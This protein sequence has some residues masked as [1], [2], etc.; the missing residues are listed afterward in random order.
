MRILFLAAAVASVAAGCGTDCDLS[1][2]PGVVVRVVNSATGAPICDATV[3]VTDGDWH[4]SVPPTV[5]NFV[6]AGVDCLFFAADERA[7]NYTVDVKAG[8]KEALYYDVLV[9]RANAC[10]VT[11]RQLTVAL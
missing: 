11:G 2:V 6:D 3:T 5:M 1:N 10:H 7:G 9:T 4:E 8:A